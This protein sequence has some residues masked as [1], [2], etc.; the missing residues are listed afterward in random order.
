MTRVFVKTKLVGSGKVTA[1]STPWK[2]NNVTT[3][4]ILADTTDNLSKWYLRQI[5]HLK[6]IM[7]DAKTFL[8]EP[9][10]TEAGLL[11][12]FCK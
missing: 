2:D 1:A 11:I 6:L 7:R 5:K 10:S 4:Y 12:I 8:Y 9:S 3:S